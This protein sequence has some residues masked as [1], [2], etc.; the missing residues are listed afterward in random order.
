MISIL[1]AA[2][3]GEKY[4][5]RCLDSYCRQTNKD[6][7][8]I[9]VN[10]GSTDSTL[11]IAKS[12][13]GKL[14]HYKIISLP[15]NR[16]LPAVRNA[17]VKA[18]TGEYITFADCDDFVDECAV[19]MMYKCIHKQSDGIFCEHIRNYEKRQLSFR[20][21][22]LSRDEALLCVLNDKKIKG[23]SWSKIFK[24][25]IIEK[26]NLRFNEKIRFCEDLN[27]AVKYIMCCD[28]IRRYDTAYYHYIYVKNSI[29][30]SGGFTD[31]KVTTLIALGEA[32][33][34]MMK[35]NID[36][37]IVNQYKNYYM[38]M[39]LSLLMYGIYTGRMSVQQRKMLEKKLY[40]YDMR[41]MTSIR[42]FTALAISRFSVDLC[43]NIWRIIK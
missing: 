32:I 8:L 22:S 19:D 39:L 26:N 12:Y 11:D 10:D 20:N 15:E 33:S 24:R 2:Y 34:I 13:I 36:K 35:G 7:E 6:F 1:V 42:I 37:N 27:F 14:P 40:K 41:D 43:Y 21:V 30:N 29:T 16:G 23:Y 25:D 17:G 5:A 18:S 31:A 4:L 9:V 3:N 28:N 38:N